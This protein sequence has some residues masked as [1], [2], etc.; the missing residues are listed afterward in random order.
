MANKELLANAPQLFPE[1][2]LQRHVAVLFLRRRTIR[3]PVELSEMHYVTQ[4]HNTFLFNM[5]CTSMFKMANKVLLILCIII[6][7]ILGC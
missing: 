3:A 1:S 5:K 7:S 4:R 6:I 2:R